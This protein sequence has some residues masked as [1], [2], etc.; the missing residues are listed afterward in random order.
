MY[1]SL[2]GILFL[3]KKYAL[4]A[5]I[6]TLIVGLSAGCM[7]SCCR[8]KVAVV[9]VP[10][11]V[12]KSVQVQ[13]LKAEQTQKAQELSQWLQKAQNDVK[14]EKN[15]DKKDALLKQYNAE[16][17]LKTETMK[18]EYAGKVQE[19]ESGITKTIIDIA[20]KKGYKYVVVKGVMLFGGDDITEA[21]ADVVK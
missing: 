21:V 20:K 19:I 6:C 15:K 12:N 8:K 4:L 11:V 16:F 14:K 10:Q 3:T 5:M 13:T 18:R 7:L 1:S 17:A 9:D 2:S